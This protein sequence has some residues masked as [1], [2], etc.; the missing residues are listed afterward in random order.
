M[1]RALMM[2]LLVLAWTGTGLAQEKSTGAKTVTLK[3]YVVDQMCARSIAKKANVM[4]KAARHTRECCFHDACAASG[5]GIFYDGKWAPFDEKG[6]DLAK[7]ALE[8]SK[9]ETGMFFV[10]Q[11]K[12]DG[13]T[14]M[15]SSLKEADPPK[16]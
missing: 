7:K 13:E 2:G 3:G 9:R 8:A 5:F 11:G 14:L 1:T 15:V 4:E 6:S 10:V 16:E 12:M